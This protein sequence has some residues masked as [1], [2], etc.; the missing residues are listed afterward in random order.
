MSP[1]RAA[2]LFSTPDLIPQFESLAGLAVAEAD[3]LI[4]LLR[5]PTDLADQVQRAKQIEHEADEIVHQIVRDLTATYNSRFE[6]EDLHQLASSLDDVIDFSYGAADRVL[7][8][9]IDQIPPAALEIAKVIHRQ[10]EELLAAVSSLNFRSAVFQHCMAVS[11]LE[12][13]ADR[14]TSAAIAE[15]FEVER[16]AIQLIKLKELYSQ[17]T[18]ATDRAKTAAQAVETMV[19]K[20]GPA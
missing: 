8:Y 14:L 13:D 12:Y 9:K 1:L 17:L 2:K 15:L 3:L 19:M 10:A 11:Q 6:R 5:Q 7:L 18:S 20:Q 16:N 4:E